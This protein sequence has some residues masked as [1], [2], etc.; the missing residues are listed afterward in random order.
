VELASAILAE[1]GYDP[2]PAYR[3]PLESL[4]STPHLAEQY[5]LVLNAGKRVAVYTNSRHR[6]ISNLRR[7]EPEA[8]AEL[9]PETARGCGVQDG[10]PVRVTSPRGSIVLQVSVTPKVR[11][12]IV[13]L[14]HGW[15][16]ANANLL[17]DERATDP[18]LACPSLRASLCRVEAVE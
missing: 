17:T 3:E 10:D 15:E 14:L 7:A 16:E 2:L 5:P 18:I 1:Y 12:G 11:E 8:L 13:S 4:L 9:G 6:N